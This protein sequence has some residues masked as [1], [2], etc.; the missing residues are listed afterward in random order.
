MNRKT[1]FLSFLTLTFTLFSCQET[2][3]RK[4]LSSQTSQEN[5]LIA[6]AQRI[7]SLY[8]SGVIDTTSLVKFVQQALDFAATYPETDIA[9]NMM[10]KAG[11]YNMRLAAMSPEKSNRIQYAK[12]ALE[13][14]DNFMEIYPD[15]KDVKFCYW[16]RGII[17]DDIL[18]MY[19]SA[20]NEYRDFLHKFPN[21]SLAVHI[22]FCL[23]NL[24]KSAEDIM[25][26]LE[27]KGH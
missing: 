12:Q 21:D 10:L 2:A 1:L 23:D 7:D 6:N 11:I 24:G 20:E 25:M 13:V 8:V 26:E 18:Q 5:Q 15:H 22:Q 9:P 4:N 19:P 14:F 16:W 27:E 17:Y 3:E